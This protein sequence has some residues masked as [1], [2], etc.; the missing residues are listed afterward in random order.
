MTINKLPNQDDV[1]GRSALHGFETVP[2]YTQPDRLTNSATGGVSVVFNDLGV[3]LDG[4]T[5]SGDTGRIDTIRS[6]A[7]QNF[8]QV[9]IEIGYVTGGTAPPYTDDVEYGVLL[10]S[11]VN[12]DRG[13][14]LD[15]T[16][17]EYHVDTATVPATLPGTFAS[18]LLRIK[19]DYAAGET[20]FTQS[21]AV[22]ESVTISA[23]D[24]GQRAAVA[25]GS[26]GN[27]DDSPSIAYYKIEMR[28]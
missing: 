5:T 2:T 13:A 11:G 23:A 21:G 6:V 17:S 4:S 22:S 16:S 14:Y 12:Q 3:R 7:Y 25:Y 26:N 24:T 28:P 1:T 10:N 15:F 9:V 18:V 27:G 19:I 8:S 20:T